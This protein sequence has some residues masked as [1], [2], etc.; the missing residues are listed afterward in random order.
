MQ[1]FLRFPW[2]LKVHADLIEEF[3][4]DELLLFYMYYYNMH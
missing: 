1:I 4:T 2:R 3:N